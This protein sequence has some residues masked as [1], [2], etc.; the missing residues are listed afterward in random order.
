M[1]RECELCGTPFRA[2]SQA[3][4][5][6]SLQCCSVLQARQ[7]A[8]DERFA[9]QACYW[10]CLGVHLYIA[11]V[12]PLGAAMYWAGVLAGHFRVHLWRRGKGD[13]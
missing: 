4:V 5:W 2:V 13:E 1:I 6:C 11:I 12:W 7:K 8:R 9:K 3:H 10:I